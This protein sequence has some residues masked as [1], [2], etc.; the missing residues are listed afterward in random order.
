MTVL[1][2]L[3]PP[4]RRL[5][6][7]SALGHGGEAGAGVRVAAEF[8]FVLSTD[9]HTPASTGRVAPALLP[10][11]DRVVAVLA[12]TDVSWH[13]LDVPKA[14]A[15]RLRAALAGA[16][17]EALLDD[18]AA[19]HFALGPLAEA[20]QNGWVAVMNRPWLVATLAEL[21]RHGVRVDKLAPASAP[22]DV[23]SGHFH[24]DEA[25]A[26]AGDDVVPTLVLGGPDGVVCL[27]LQGQ[28]AR[29]LL[30]GAAG[31]P[32]AAPPRWTATPAAAAAA[33][34]WL[35]GPVTVLGD[36]ERALQAARDAADLRQFDLA[37][38]HRGLQALREAGRGLLKPEW[39]PVR[40]GLAALVGLQIVGLNAWAWQQQRAIEQRQ[41]AM[42]ELLKRSHPQVRAVLDAPVQMQR[43]TEQ[44]R[45]RAGR[46]G[47]GDLELLLAAAAAA[48]P[49]GQP[50]VQ[51]LR[52]E[53][54]RLTLA[55][56]DWDDGLLQAFRERLRPAGYAAELAEGRV[57]LS[58]AVAPPRGRA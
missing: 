47:E 5:A 9:G 1:V 44:L 50:P 40:W 18:D 3:I 10:R 13:R 27:R 51:T 33:E 24:I 29:A 53:S 23:I 49:D 42:V 28:L 48:W 14:P 55:A 34:R 8:P 17:E 38:R 52:F 15:A 57:T 31:T 4:R 30:P 20:G 37:P 7:R 26:D 54:G 36:A 11:A 43:E 16:M 46:P 41:A 58:R 21:A 39:R 35:G 45:A 25:D 56:S 12:D 32:D 6:A 22:Q 19:L 2:I